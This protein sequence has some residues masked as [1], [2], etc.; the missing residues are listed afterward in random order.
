VLGRLTASEINRRV[1]ELAAKVRIEELLHRMP[2]ELSGGQQQRLAIA[3]ALAKEPR[4]LVMDEPLVNIDYKLREELAGEL[5]SLVEN[6]DTCLVY[7]TSDPRDSLSLGDTTI[8]LQDGE[9]LQVGKPLDVYRYPSSFKAADLL[10]DPSINRLGASQAIRP[11]HVLLEAVDGRSFT[12]RITGVETNGAE[13]YLHADVE[14]GDEEQT[15]P[16]VV[17]LKGMKDVHPGEQLTF[18]L[19]E[20]DVL[21]FKD[22]ERRGASR[23]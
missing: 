21:N 9:V 1:R 11:E 14:L 8:L 23:G 12:A 17:K 6:T 15:C 16:W 20:Q 13:T 22:E 19:R 3:R 2:D 7:C 5:K 18:H 10:S 4:V